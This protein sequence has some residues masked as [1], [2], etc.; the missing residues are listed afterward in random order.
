MWSRDG[1]ELFFVM[2][3]SMMAVQVTTDP[4]FEVSRP[5]LLFQGDFFLSSPANQSY[6]VASD[7]R[8]LMV[9]SGDPAQQLRMQLIVQNNW[10]EVLRQR[11]GSN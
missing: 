6:D 4:G 1:S 11:I 5:E 7:G 9:Q 10:P 8:F 3:D 2:G